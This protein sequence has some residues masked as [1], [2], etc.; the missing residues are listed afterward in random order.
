MAGTK[1][2]LHDAAAVNTTRRALYR[3][4]LAIELPVETG[5]GGRTKWNR[6]ERGLPKTHWLDAACVG[7][8]TPAVLHI[9]GVGPLL[10][11]ACGHGTRQLCGT[12]RAGF[13]IRHRTRHN[14]HFG[15]ATGDLVRAV[16]PAGLKTAGQ[17]VGR[18]LVRAGGQFDLAT[19]SGRMPGINHRYCRLVAHGDGY[20]YAT[21]RSG[22]SSPA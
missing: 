21:G 4:L 12:N 5:T 6:A 10:I 1:P 7:A 22:V 13:P 20:A 8:S 14:R 19:V 11:S 3:R 16:V 9:A 15:F 17:H 2:P 18:V